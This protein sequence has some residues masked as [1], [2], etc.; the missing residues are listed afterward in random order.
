MSI[1]KELKLI[2]QPKVIDHLGIKMYQKPVDVISEFIANAWDG[3]SEIA[4]IT[5]NDDSIVVKDKGLGMT[6]DQCQ[7]YFLV[8]GRDRRKSTGKE[9]TEEKKR[10]VLGRKGIG[11]FAGFGI[12]RTIEIKTVS[13]SNGEATTFV[14]DLDEILEH[15]MLNQSSKPIKVIEYREPNPKNISQSG[16]IVTL[17][18]VYN[19]QI[20][21]DGF[22]NEL[23]RR[24]LLPQMYDD[25]KV[26]VNNIDLPESFGT[27]LDI[28]FPKDLNSQEKRK[29]PNL[30]SVDDK[31]WALKK[32][33]G[34]DVQWRI[35]FYEEPIETEELRGIAIFVKG[36]LAQK[37]FV[38]DMV[39]G[40]SGQHAIEYMTGQVKMDFIDVGTN[41]L[42]ATERQRINL[43]TPL[44]GKIKTWGIE[45]I[46][47]LTSFW[48]TRRSEQRLKEL[49][50]KLSGFKERLENIPAT[51]RKTIKSVLSK[52]ASFERLGKKRFQEW[53]NTI[54]TSWETGRL[55]DLITEISKA[56]DLDEGKLLE[57][58][59]E[60]DVLTALNIAESVKTKILAIGEL[61][62]RVI[63][64]QLENK[65]RDYIY[66][67]PW[68]IHPKWESFK[69]ER[70]VNNLIQDA[71]L[72]FLNS[73]A[74][75]GRVDLV[76]SAGD[77]LLLLEFIRPGL[78]IDT[79][80]LDRIN[81]YVMEIRTSIEKETGNDIRR[82][83]SAYLIADS[84]KNNETINKRIKQLE[85][86]NIYVMT[87]NTLIEQA[88]KQWK[89]YLSLLK[90]RN[91]K[92]KRIQE[93]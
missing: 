39:G 80:H 13:K 82:L 89:D 67:H 27:D 57:I 21:I 87:W 74:F 65:V 90:Q 53:C 63:S 8:V 70:S 71:G 79:D 66:E 86:D 40:I 34:Y 44:G 11:K 33:D 43:Q 64:K 31:G 49:D 37:P 46:K 75:K 20:D 29:I 32:L 48:K 24:F 59:A 85:K 72:K 42:I 76:L 51:E 17:R 55:K 14:M 58:L 78:E 2:I 61:K 18:G 1:K 93:L 22:R 9:L 4:D 15:D 36:K 62:Q 52:I 54:L 5:I 81:Y 56:R 69:K 10:P 73:E 92:D 16:T 3:D 45:R 88:I 25:F 68:I 84:K 19:K 6:F 50:D 91:P 83:N 47:L 23:S 12:A 60:A 41:D 77:S 7:N 30:V 35:G 26:K 28:I 38:F